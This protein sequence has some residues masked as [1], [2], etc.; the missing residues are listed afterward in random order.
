MSRALV[1]AALA[2]LAFVALA[3]RSSSSP[4]TIAIRRPIIST[5]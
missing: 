5:E 3:R 1:W 4:T 2:T